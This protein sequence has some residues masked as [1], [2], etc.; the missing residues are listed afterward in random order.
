M[1]ARHTL[2]VLLTA[3]VGCALGQSNTDLTYARIKYK[4]PHANG[5]VD[6]LEQMSGRA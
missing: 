5:T 6:T 4:L 1:P 3:V 2:V